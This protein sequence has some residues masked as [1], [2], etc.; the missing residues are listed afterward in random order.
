M[1]ILITFAII[2]LVLFLVMILLK[3]EPIILSDTR[4]SNVW[5]SEIYRMV[6]TAKKQTLKGKYKF[7]ISK[8]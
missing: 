5:G 6:F 4:L 2:A 3:I 7:A 8:G 1:W